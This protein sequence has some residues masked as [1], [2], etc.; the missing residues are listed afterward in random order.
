VAADL[1]G[2][3]KV[4]LIC[5][6]YNGGAFS[7]IPVLTNNG[8]GGFVLETNISMALGS[9]VQSV[10]TADVNGDGKVDLIAANFQGNSGAVSV[11][12]N[13]GNGFFKL[14]SSPGAGGFL[15]PSVTTADVNGDG[16]VDLIYADYQYYAAS[17]PAVTI[18]TNTGNGGFVL[19]TNIPNN[20]VAF[21]PVFV[22][23]VDVNG[24]GKV[25]LILA[26]QGRLGNNSSLIVL[27]NNGSGVFVQATYSDMGTNGA[28]WI[29]A[30]DF[31][32][33]GKLDI[34]CANRYSNSV[35]VFFNASIF[36]PPTSTPPLN[37]KSS[38]N[39]LR[40]SWS[41]A[42]AGW[43]LQQNPDLTTTHWGPSGYNGYPISDDRTNKSLTIPS[44]PGN[45][46][47]RL[48]HP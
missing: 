20:N 31:N 2:D 39:G 13:N 15:P 23:A 12:T 28:N 41:S 34:A 26:S 47:F 27:T 22:T 25:D 7:T 14:S 37:I 3:G 43:S 11:F 17:S 5:S 10:T 45:L 38:G 8:S 36:P 30:A 35:S 1:N 16:K 48:L 46:F 44:P 21:A 33:D 6:C 18:L 29:A 32:G 4:D 40:V 19:Y 9:Y 42:S 24:D